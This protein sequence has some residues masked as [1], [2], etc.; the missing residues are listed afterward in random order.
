MSAVVGVC[1]PVRA[2]GPEAA[3]TLFVR[4]QQSRDQHARDL[5]FARYEPLARKLARRYASTSEPLDD[6]VQVAAVGLL[7]AIDRF[8]PQ[9]GVDFPAFAIPTI[10]G[11]L[12]RYYRGT[13]W[14]AHVPRGAQELALRVDQASRELT[15]QTG[16][17]ADIKEVARFLKLDLADVLTG[18]E[19]GHAHF[20]TSLN[21]PVTGGEHD[22]NAAELGELI[23]F[24]D[25]GYALTECAMSVRQGLSGLPLLERRALQLRLD[26]NLKQ[27]E[28]ADLMGCSQMQVSRLLRRAAARLRAL[29]D[30]GSDPRTS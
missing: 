12:K 3:F 13:G 30:P 9:R 22:D 29:M 19:A 28:I 18:L 27:S 7:G 1:A 6:L 5:L 4:W 26:D 10:L 21:A 14:A 8:D 11:E 17:P 2:D 25:D 24:E 15:S 23:G 16:R 20:A